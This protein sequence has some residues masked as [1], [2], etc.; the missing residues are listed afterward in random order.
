M[1]KTQ[2]VGYVQKATISLVLKEK[3]KMLKN[4]S[5]KCSICENT[6][7]REDIKIFNR[8]KN[9]FNHYDCEMKKQKKMRK[10]Y[11]R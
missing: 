10:R 2:Q 7:D 11:G 6:V 5:R 3:L 1:I 8:K 4:I 9:N